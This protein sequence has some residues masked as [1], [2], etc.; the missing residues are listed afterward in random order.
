MSRWSV[1]PRIV[2]IIRWI[3]RIW[4]ILI[5][6]LAVLVIRTPDPWVVEPV[7][8]ADRIAMGLFGAAILGSLIAWRWEGLGGAIAIASVVGDDVFVRITRGGG[9]WSQVL[10]PAAPLEFLFGLPGILFL[11]CWALSRSKRG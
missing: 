1:N 7:P 11:V 4:S 8:L 9:P 6:A 3:A 10:T 5:F 2:T